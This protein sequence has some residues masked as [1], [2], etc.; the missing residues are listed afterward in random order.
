[1]SRFATL[2]FAVAAYAI[3]FATF[4]YLICFVGNFPFAP[5]TVDRGPDAPVAAAIVINL[6]LV[7]LFG[8]QQMSLA[9]CFQRDEP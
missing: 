7:A 2:L 6:A 4:L 8:V 1:M 3:F 9:A 5:L